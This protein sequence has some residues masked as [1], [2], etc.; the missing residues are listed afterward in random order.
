MWLSIALLY[1]AVPLAPDEWAW[2]S[3]DYMNMLTVLLLTVK[4]AM[5]GE[6]LH[7]IVFSVF[8]Y[9][10]VEYT[11]YMLGFDLWELWSIATYPMLLFIAAHAVLY[12]D[13]I[14]G[15]NK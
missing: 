5:R 7:T 8:F 14:R 3:F 13:K 1:A 9:N 12:G 11:L 4:G 6:M 10:M 2:A 15:L